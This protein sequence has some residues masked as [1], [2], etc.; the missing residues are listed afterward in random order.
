MSELLVQLHSIGYTKYIG[1]VVKFRC[2]TVDLQKLESVYEDMKHDLTIWRNKCD[3]IRTKYPQLNY[4][5]SEQLLYLQK[6]LAALNLVSD[7]CECPIKLLTLLQSVNLKVNSEFVLYSMK[8]AKDSIQDLVSPLQLESSI[9]PQK[10]LLFEQ[11]LHNLTPYQLELC[12]ELKKSSGFTMGLLIKGLSEISV[13][14]D[15]SPINSLREWCSVNAVSDDSGSTSS[16]ELSNFQQNLVAQLEAEN[17]SKVLIINGLITNKIKDD[18]KDLLY[19]WCITNESEQSDDEDDFMDEDTDAVV[20]ST[21]LSSVVDD[22]HPLVLQLI[23]EYNLETAIK[24]VRACEE[25]ATIE[26]VRKAASLI[27]D[28]MEVEVQSS[29]TSKTW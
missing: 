28:G 13:V 6:E 17:I 2:A 16:A 5:T 29:S 24:A 27:S 26:S 4:F 20:E 18:P 25:N 22:K 1:F 19:K 8:N 21:S 23:E 10:S 9:Q 15:D 11:R 14:T 3:R 12:K 7:N